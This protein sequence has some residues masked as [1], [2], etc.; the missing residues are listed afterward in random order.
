MIKIYITGGLQNV[1]HWG[2]VED[3]KS[4]RERKKHWC[5]FIGIKR[6]KVLLFKTN[7][8]CLRYQRIITTNDTKTTLRHYTV[9]WRQAIYSLECISTHSIHPHMFV[10]LSGVLSKDKDRLWKPSSQLLSHYPVGW[11]CQVCQ[12]SVA[13][14]FWPKTWVPSNRPAVSSLH[15]RGVSAPYQCLS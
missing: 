9:H 12:V 4:E 14:I 7:I 11:L 5:G 3:S 6:N 2:L 10:S 15:E 13:S 8:L 1:S